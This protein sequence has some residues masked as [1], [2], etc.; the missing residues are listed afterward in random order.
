LWTLRLVRVRHSQ[1]FPMVGIDTR[2]ALHPS[3][4]AAHRQDA[5]E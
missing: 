3:S 5:E 2:N 1:G 4:Q